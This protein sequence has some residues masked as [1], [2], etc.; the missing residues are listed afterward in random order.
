MRAPSALPSIPPEGST[1]MVDDRAHPSDM[2]GTRKLMIGGS[3]IAAVL[4]VGLLAWV[5]LRPFWGT[6]DYLGRPA[7][8]ADNRTASTTVGTGVPAQR[9]A[10]SAVAKDDPAGNESATGGPARHIKQRTQPGAL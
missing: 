4:F 8:G 1:R 3:V 10:Q 2:E 9:E 6:P 7:T 5:A